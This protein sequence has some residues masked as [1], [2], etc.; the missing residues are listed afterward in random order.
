MA[1]KMKSFDVRGV[2]VHVFPDGGVKI[3]AKNKAASD[4]IMQYMIDENLI[5][6][7]NFKC[8]RHN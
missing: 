6:L 2:R 1:A 7:D 8:N 3:Y 4:A 5:P